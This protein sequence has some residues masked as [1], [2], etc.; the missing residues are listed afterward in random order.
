MLIKDPYIEAWM[1][2]MSLN[3]PEELNQYCEDCG[4]PMSVLQVENYYCMECAGENTET[5]WL[6]AGNEM[7]FSRAQAYATLNQ[8]HLHREAIKKLKSALRRPS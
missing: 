2:E 4:E 3:L 7:K 8:I 6:A 1:R 5:P